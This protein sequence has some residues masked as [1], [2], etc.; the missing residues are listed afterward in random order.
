MHRIDGYGAVEVLPASTAVGQMAGFFSGGDPARGQVSTQVTYD[1]ANAVQEEIS[2]VI[3]GA[4]IELDKTDNTQLLSAIQEI[5]RKNLPEAFPTGTHLSFN[6]AS[7]PTG[8]TKLVDPQ[9]EGATIRFTTGDTVA[10]GGTQLFEEAFKDHEVNLSIIGDV[11][12]TTLS[13]AQMPSHRHS[14][15]Y[16]VVKLQWG[17]GPVGVNGRISSSNLT[18]YTGSSES[19]THSST[20]LSGS[21]SLSLAVKYVDFII[22]EK[23]E[24]TVTLSEVVMG[25]V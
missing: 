18:S 3:E 5:I 17:S 16:E 7:A 4:E 22:C 12:A 15:T 19:H 24:T 13:E 10:T 23:S 21:A 2:G 9:Y 20:G 6:Q 8:W 14:A 1:W 25:E 11:G